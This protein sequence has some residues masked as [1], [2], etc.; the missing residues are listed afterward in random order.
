MTECTVY[1]LCLLEGAVCF[2]PDGARYAHLQKK[3]H[4]QRRFKEVQRLLFSPLFSICINFSKSWFP[5][6]RHNKGSVKRWLR[7][8]SPVLELHAMSI[9]YYVSP[10]VFHKWSN[11]TSVESKCQNPFIEHES[12]RP[13]PATYLLTRRDVQL[14]IADCTIKPGLLLESRDVSMVNPWMYYCALGTEY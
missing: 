7:L 10:R 3:K 8:F 9:M 5:L 11:E 4:H 1:T 2:S 12:S 6:W 14:W 13:R